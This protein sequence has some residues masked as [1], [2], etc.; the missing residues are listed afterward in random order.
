MNVHTICSRM[1]AVDRNS[2]SHLL[3]CMTD[4][5]FLL[6][7]LVTSYCTYVCT[8]VIIILWGDKLQNTVA[9]PSMCIIIKVCPDSS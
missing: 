6:M 3:S 9:N 1:T 5:D 8:E 2:A 7:L 4:M